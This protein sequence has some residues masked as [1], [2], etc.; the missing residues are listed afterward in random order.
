MMN[1]REARTWMS[2]YLDSE[3]GPTKT[4]EVSE[5]LRTCAACERRFDRERRADQLMASRLG[6]TEMPGELWSRIGRE[7]ST[8][9]WVRSLRSPALLA[10]AACVAL[11]ILATA[12]FHEGA[13]AP[14]APPIVRAFAALTPE[15]RPFARRSSEPSVDINAALQEAVSVP[16]V[17]APP[18]D[19]FAAHKLEVIEIVRQTDQRGRTYS[20]V[21]IN[22]C[23]QPVLLVLAEPGDGGL[24]AAFRDLPR[25]GGPFAATFD[26]VNVAAHDLGGVVAVAVSRHP[27]ADLIAHLQRPA[28]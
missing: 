5:H 11:A 3:L 27:V 18:S 28:A 24:P 25:T 8:P 15:D 23:G 20:E 14:L 6:T 7:V 1:C 10:L 26:G 17:M 9:R 4:F 22:C 19:S 2:P 21:R 13:G 16:L 12:V